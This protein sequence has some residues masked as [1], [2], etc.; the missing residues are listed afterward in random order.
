MSKGNR[1]RNLSEENFKRGE[2]DYEKNENY[3]YHGTCIKR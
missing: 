2:I 1:I 3:L